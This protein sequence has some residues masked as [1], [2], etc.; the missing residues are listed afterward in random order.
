[1]PTTPKLQ[2]LSL[3]NNWY[4]LPLP[5]CR[6]AE[7]LEPTLFGFV[8]E[9]GQRKQTS[10]KVIWNDFWQSYINY[11]SGKWLQIHCMDAV[12]TH[13]HPYCSVSELYYCDSEVLSVQ[14]SL[15]HHVG[16]SSSFLTSF[17]SSLFKNFSQLSILS[18]LS[19][20]VSST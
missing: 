20:S 4:M 12:S 3:W 10:L 14:N 9:V 18:S 19:L 2:C 13:P 1:M 6:V 11:H 8:N 15:V 17:S 5:M 7:T 16:L